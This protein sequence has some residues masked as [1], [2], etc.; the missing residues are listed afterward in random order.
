MAAGVG[1]V[2][3]LAL[4][5]L[6]LGLV[7]P[8][9]YQGL[10]LRTDKEEAEVGLAAEEVEEAVAAVPVALGVPQGTRAQLCWR[11]DLLPSLGLQLETDHLQSCAAFPPL[12]SVRR[13]HDAVEVEA[14]AAEREAEEE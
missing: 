4:A 9:P 8:S 1:R 11:P 10:D 12:A 5:Q 13:A 2:L 6:V 14:E 3:G 7:L